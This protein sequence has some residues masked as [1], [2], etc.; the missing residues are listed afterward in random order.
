MGINDFSKKEQCWIWFRSLMLTYKQEQEILACESDMERVFEYAKKHDRIL[1][2]LPEQLQTHLYRHAS[3][4]YL[5]DACEQ[6]NRNNIRVILR[7][8]PHYPKNLHHMFQPPNLLYVRGKNVDFS[9]QAMVTIVGMR[10]ASE[11]GKRITKMIAEMIA[12]ADICVVSGLAYGIDAQ[13]HRGALS[14]K[15]TS[16]TLAVLT[17]GL[18]SIYPGEHIELAQQIMEQGVLISEHPPR[19]SVRTYHVPQRNRIMAGLAHT[20]I[21]PEA[22]YQS[23]SRH[24]V[25]WGLEYGREIFALPGQIDAKTA[26]LPNYLIQL[27]AGSILSE[28]DV[29]D[30]CKTVLQSSGKQSEVDPQIHLTSQKMASK[31]DSQASIG[32]TNLSDDEI[33]IM[34]LLQTKPMSSDELCYESKKPVHILLMYLTKLEQ[35]NMIQKDTR[36]NLFY[37]LK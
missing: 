4:N 27:G 9:Q 17:G 2:T 21:L 1:S 12:Q 28:E 10:N 25:V 33:A 7:D 14:T 16:A 37:I 34:N 35:K 18:D 36:T 5:N 30:I 3:E 32:Y 6:L 26:Q 22:T 31:V 15:K 11:Y 20:I 13:A 24:T 19:F 23:G 29:W 8:E